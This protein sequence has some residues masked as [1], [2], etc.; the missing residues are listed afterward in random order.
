MFTQE[1]KVNAYK[2]V[3]LQIKFS[4]NWRKLTFKNLEEV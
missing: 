2:Y 3:P 1:K 4:E